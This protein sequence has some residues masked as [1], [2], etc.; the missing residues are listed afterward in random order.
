MTTIWRLP[1]KSQEFEQGPVLE[2]DGDTVR[3]DYDFET[4]SGAYAW[5]AIAFVGLATI[6]FTVA[7]QCSPEQIRAYDALEECDGS[8]LMSSL[9]R[10]DDGLHHYRIFFDDIGCYDVVCRQFV[11]PSA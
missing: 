1:V 5:E 8:E 11:P 2:W 3:I 9:M 6:R 7:D 4:D 10:P